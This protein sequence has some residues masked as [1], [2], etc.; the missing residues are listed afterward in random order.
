MFKSLTND[1]MLDSDNLNAN[2]NLNKLL[3]FAIYI[4]LF[5]LL[6]FIIPCFLFNRLKKESWNSRTMLRLVPFQEI[7]EETIKEMKEYTKI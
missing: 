2:Q 7:S 6:I 5:F 4:V 3:V 1:L